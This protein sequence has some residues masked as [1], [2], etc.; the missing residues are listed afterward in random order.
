MLEKCDQFEDHGHIC[1]FTQRAQ[2]EAAGLAERVDA[3]V[4]VGG[5]DSSN[6]RRL[7][8]VCAERCPTFHVE[9]A[10]ELR[11]EW[12]QGAEHGGRHGRGLHAGR[13][14]SRRS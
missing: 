4:V 2:E 13:R 6:T 11:P 10:A 8:E 1:D 12:F 7:V 9:T 3:M 5:K 14:T